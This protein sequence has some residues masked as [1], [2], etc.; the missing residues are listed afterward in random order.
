M[1]NIDIFPSIEQERLPTWFMNNPCRVCVLTGYA[2]TGK[3]KT[4]ELLNKYLDGKAVWCS[5]SHQAA[6]VL[7]N[8]A[9]VNAITLASVLGLGRKIHEG[10]EVF[11]PVYRNKIDGA[12]Y[13]IVDEASMISKYHLSLILEY[14]KCKILFVGDPAQLPPVK[15]I[16][17]PV[18]TKFYPTHK[19]TKVFRNS[20]KIIAFANDIRESHLNKFSEFGIKTSTIQNFYENHNDGIAVCPTHAQKELCNTIAKQVLGKNNS[21]FILESSVN[22]PNGPSNGSVVRIVNKSKPEIY[23][24]F[25]VVRTENSI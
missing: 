4:L 7:S 21:M 5:P 2:G 20:D 14:D 17:S 8:S 1:R 9:G 23:M 12:K 25:T 16:E 22:P 24:G 11:V 3:T 13:L 6:S 15:E 19:L 18:F 10:K